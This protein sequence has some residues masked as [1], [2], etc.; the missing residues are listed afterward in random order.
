MSLIRASGFTIYQSLSHHP[1]LILGID[2]LEQTLTAGLLGTSL[3]FPLR[4]RAKI[5]RQRTCKALGYPVPSSFRRTRPRFPGQNFDL[6]VQKSNN[7]QIW[8]ESIVNSRRYVLVRLGDNDRVTSV[9]VID[10]KVL[11]RLDHSDTLTHKYQA[12]SIDPITDSRLVS[13]TDTG[14][15]MS[16]IIAAKRNKTDDTFIAGFQPIAEVFESLSQLVGVRLDNPGADQERNRG[17][18]LHVAAAHCLGSDPDDDGQ[19]PDLADQLIEIKLQTSTTV[20]LGVV[21]PA[22]E[23]IISQHADAK[24]LGI[25]HCD[26]RY[27]L[28]YASLDEETDE[29]VIEHIVLTTGQDFFQC[30]RQ[31]GGLEKNSKNQIALPKDFW[32]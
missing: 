7:L 15:V 4:T 24:R 29:V 32:N 21:H 27:A 14:N 3:D 5:A 22:S 30:F 12:T 23:E 28:F 18:G 25:R 31:F 10:G 1:E 16:H 11:A 9:R 26:V 8:N 17:A 20:D 2:E 6:Y 13:S 19:F